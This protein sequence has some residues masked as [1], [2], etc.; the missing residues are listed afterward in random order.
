MCQ[1]VGCSGGGG[2]ANQQLIMNERCLCDSCGCFPLIKVQKMS[3]NLNVRGTLTRW[4]LALEAADRTF[5]LR[6]H[7]RLLGLLFY[8]VCR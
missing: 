5:V 8:L 4:C 3:E 6:Q 7:L 1:Q 2:E